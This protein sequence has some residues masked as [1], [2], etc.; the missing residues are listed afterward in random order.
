MVDFSVVLGVDAKTIQQLRMSS[1]TWRKNQP[2]LW[3][4]P[5]VVFYDWRQVRAAEVRAA[6]PAFDSL[7]MSTLVP[8][9]R[10]PVEPPG[11]YENQRH[12]MLAG[13][14][15]VPAEYVATQYWLKIDTD[16]VKLDDRDWPLPEWFRPSEMY[17]SAVSRVSGPVKKP[18]P[19]AWISS[20]WGY[21]K[22]AGQMAYLE[23]WA[24][25]V[26][27]LREFPRVGFQDGGRA[28][29]RLRHPRMA[30]WVSFYRLDFTRDAAAWANSGV[31]PG[32]IPVPSQDG[33][34]F[35]VSA[36][37]REPVRTV[38]MKQ[39]GWANHSRIANLEKAVA[40]ILA[41]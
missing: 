34:H 11:A 22:P 37:T 31:E 1:Q 21:T 9:P 38:S 7:P 4:R 8:W 20:P 23:A 33:Y 41:K 12:R 3:K 36:R 39:H 19:P 26:P 5:W 27:G 16:A 2:D 13:F 29:R 25:G 17:F 32:S 40:E 35:Y 18:R 14:I 10:V 15:H 28:A 6:I 30:S 24:D